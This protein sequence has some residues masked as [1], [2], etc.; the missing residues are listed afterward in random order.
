MG[1]LTKVFSGTSIKSTTHRVPAKYE[2]NFYAY[3]FYIFLVVFDTCMIWKMVCE[4]I[5]KFRSSLTRTLINRPIYLI[6]NYIQSPIILNQ[7]IT[8]FI[9]SLLI[10]NQSLY[11]ITHSI[12][13][14][15][16]LFNPPHFCNYVLTY[17]V[18]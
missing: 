6:I 4:Q 13:S 7:S 3:F 16:L 12:Q 14:L 10:F 9:Q 11:S 15:T 5:E 18:L 1:N 8:H 2:R 17:Y